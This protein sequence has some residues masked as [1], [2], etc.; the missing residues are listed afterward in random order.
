MSSKLPHSLAL[1]ANA[2]MPSQRA[3]SLQV[4]QM[5]AAFQR[6]G[7]D[8]TLVHALRNPP[9]PPLAPG[10]SLWEHYEAGEKP[11]P[12]AVAIP[13]F[14]WIDRFPVRAQFAPARLQEWSFSRNAARWIAMHRPDAMVLSREVEAARALL[15]L[16]MEKIF[17]EI[18]RV[19]GG[20]LRRAW[21]KEVCEGV[22]GV[23]AISE[24]I[25]DDLVE[26]GYCAPEKI[27][28]ER[29]GFAEQRFAK[30]PS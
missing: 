28:V 18:H 14:D 19:P 17:L 29:D 7:F 12:E 24:G 16:R 27:V 15:T 4:A 9:G 1:V 23:L 30:I 5:T 6:A 25:R 21:L 10:V 22:R 2:R 20:R 11:W 13:H 26:D 3:Q 8:S